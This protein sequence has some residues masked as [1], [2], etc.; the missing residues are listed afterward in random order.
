MIRLCLFLLLLP[1]AGYSQWRGWRFDPL[2]EK[3]GLNSNDIRAIVQD[4][5]GY[6]YFGGYQQLIRYDG[7]VFEDF[8]HDPD[9]PNSIGPGQISQMI[10]SQDGSIC[11]SMRRDG[12]NI[13]DPVSGHFTRY[14]APVPSNFT[15]PIFEDEHGDIWLGADDFILLRFSKASASFS[16]WQPDANIFPSGEKAGITG[17]LQDQT[18]PQ[19]LWISSFIYSQVAYPGR[20]AYRLIQFDRRT[21]TFKNISPCAGNL[22]YQDASGRLWGGSWSSGLVRF[23]PA[24]RQCDSLRFDIVFDSGEQSSDG[25]FAIHPMHNGT[26]WIGSRNS[27]LS[28]NDPLQHHFLLKETGLGG[29]NVMYTDRTH[30]TWVGTSNGLKVY[31]PGS[32]HIDFFSLDQFGVHDRI[33]PGRLAFHPG[34]QTL[35]LINRSEPR[36]YIIPLDRSRKADFIPTNMPLSAVAVDQKGQVLVTSRTG[37][38]KV[39]PLRRSLLPVLSNTALPQPLPGLWSMQTQ[40]DGWVVALGSNELFWFKDVH[41]KIHSRHFTV[42]HQD[43]V[44]HAGLFLTSDGRALLSDGE[45]MHVVHLASGEERE[46]LSKEKGHLVQDHEGYYWLGTINHVGRY[47]LRGDSLERIRYITAKDGLVNITASQLH[48]DLRGRIWIFSNSGMSVID[49]STWQTRNIG[50]PEG[51]PISA[52]DPVQVITL[53]D[54]RL[55]TVCANGIIVFHPDSLWNASAPATV[56]VVLTSIRISGKENIQP[57]TLHAKSPIQ[58]APHQH[59]LDIQFQGLAFPHDRHVRYSYRVAGLHDNW[60]SSGKNNAVTLSQ[61]PP[62]KY[63]FEVKAG[64]PETIAAVTSFDFNIAKPVYMRTWFLAVCFLIFLSIVYAIYRYRLHQIRLQEEAKTKIHRQMAE[65][66]LQA[67]RAQ[68]NPH[69]MFNSLNSIKNYILKNETSKAA[70]YLS[71]FA[72]LIRLIL[73][74]TREKTITLR[75]EIETL[76]LYVDLEKLRFRNGFQF[77]CQID[78]RIDVS[79]V[80]IPPMIIQPYIENAIWHGLLHKEEDRQLSLQVTTDGHNV[81]CEVKDNGIGRIQ[82]AAIKSKSAT[83]YKSMGM[84]ITADRITLMNAVNALGIR[85][86]V[87]DIFTDTGAPGGTLVKIIIPH[88]RDTD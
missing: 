16:S 56:D 41:D 81:V 29:V 55:S 22:K 8:T 35:Y 70:E 21:E 6:M 80:H 20:A 58:L 54:G 53:P 3:D 60:I 68:M 1:A 78:E 72:H 59:T 48:V 12:L 61:L 26:T 36:L 37:I 79:H 73:Q 69:F 66:E 83:R 63:T 77:S 25:V 50:V 38:F 87:Q 47:T 45:R 65:L 84:G 5:Q 19:I 40:Q 46:I 24:T 44:S 85:V 64:L 67:L 18:N 34:E 15:D 33:Y 39:D 76:L 13:F 49:P 32:Q 30:N 43:Q 51:L 4:Q 9:D 14:A 31:H 27:L 75:E 2:T 42:E 88:A 62:G 11:L 74:H 17:I 28:V 71:N 23:N 82:A 10:L 52:M 57:L 86:D 7:H